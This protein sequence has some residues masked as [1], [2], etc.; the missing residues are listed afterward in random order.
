MIIERIK[1][2]RKPIVSQQDG[3]EETDE[4]TGD[5]LHPLLE[6]I[7]KERWYPRDH[8]PITLDSVID[9]ILSKLPNAS[10]TMLKTLTS[11]LVQLNRFEIHLV[12]VLFSQLIFVRLDKS[13]FLTNNSIVWLKLYSHF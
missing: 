13:V 4:Q 9:A 6:K 8:S 7:S 2:Q 12:S 10:K 3:G 11:Y 1:V 5:R